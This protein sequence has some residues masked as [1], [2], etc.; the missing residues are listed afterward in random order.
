MLI[1]SKQCPKM[2]ETKQVMP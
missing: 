1:P 2:D